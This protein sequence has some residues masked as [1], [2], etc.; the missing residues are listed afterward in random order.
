VSET[1]LHVRLTDQLHAQLK[2]WAEHEG[3]SLNTFAI[4]AL[5][6]HL[7]ALAN[8]TQVR[9]DTVVLTL[10]RLVQAVERLTELLTEPLT[11]P[12]AEPP[13]EKKETL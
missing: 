8:N 1:Q 11:G 4:E 5:H 10:E 3:V 13:A 7:A 6:A 12:P 9:D 2:Y